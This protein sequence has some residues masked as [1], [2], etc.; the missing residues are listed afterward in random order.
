MTE[1]PVFFETSFVNFVS[2]A[3]RARFGDLHFAGEMVEN[4]SK[5]CRSL[6]GSDGCRIISS[7]HAHN[8]GTVRSVIIVQITLQNYQITE[9]RKKRKK[10]KMMIGSCLG[11]TLGNSRWEKISDPCE[12]HVPQPSMSQ[13]ILLLNLCHEGRI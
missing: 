4:S 2:Q 13:H 1:T 3:Y 12:L 7:T 5:A 9:K 6:K 10:K 8:N 11:Q